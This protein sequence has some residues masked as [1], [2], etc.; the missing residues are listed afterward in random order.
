MPE[1]KYGAR[2][3]Y[4]G[5]LEIADQFDCAIEA[6]DKFG[7]LSYLVLSTSMGETISWEFGPIIPDS[8]SIPEFSSLSVAR[9]DSDSKAISKK[10]S[11]FLNRKPIVS[12]TEVSPYEAL[13]SYIDLMGPLKERLKA[14]RK[15]TQ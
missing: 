4:D 10:I 1:F 13:A 5:L 3:E 2:K 15:E 6:E 11:D 8:T 7:M 14:E 12:A 9:F